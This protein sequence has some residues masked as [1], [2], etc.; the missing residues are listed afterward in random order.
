MAFDVPPVRPSVRPPKESSNF[1]DVLMCWR[2]LTFKSVCFGILT[3]KIP[4]LVEH[5]EDLLLLFLFDHR[6]AGQS[7]VKRSH[8]QELFKAVT[9]GNSV[10]AMTVPFY[11]T[12]HDCTLTLY[13]L[14]LDPPRQH[15]NMIHP[16]TTPQHYTPHNSTICVSQQVS[17]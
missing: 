10:Y 6:L 1:M 7:V 4:Y 13:T 12:P 5:G 11:H 3:S 9:D 15:Q 14:P 8:V 17:E 2:I 16:L